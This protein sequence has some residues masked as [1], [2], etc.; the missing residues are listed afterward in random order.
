MINVLTPNCRDWY[1]SFYAKSTLMLYI[2]VVEEI[3]FPTWLD[4]YA[5][6]D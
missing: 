2:D 5:L 6:M 4:E 3:L 1:L